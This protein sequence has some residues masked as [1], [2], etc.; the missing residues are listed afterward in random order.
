MPTSLFPP[1]PLPHPG[2]QNPVRNLETGIRQPCVDIKATLPGNSL[3]FQ[4][5]GLLTFT[6]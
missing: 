5:L 1:P 2:W 3:A 6:A 4:R